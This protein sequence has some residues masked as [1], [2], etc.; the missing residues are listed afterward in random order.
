MFTSLVLC[1]FFHGEEATGSCPEQMGCPGLFTCIPQ[2]K[3]QSGNFK[4]TIAATAINIGGQ[5][6]I[7]IPS[8]CLVHTKSLISVHLLFYYFWFY[9]I[10]QC[11][12][13]YHIDYLQTKSV[14]YRL[15]LSSL[16]RF[17]IRKLYLMRVSY[18]SRVAQLVISRD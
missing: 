11:M 15:L 14:K 5:L 1:E 2:R 8:H 6:I 10:S 18:L 16:F 3:I 13:L 9:S 12:K 17:L 4:D 7:L